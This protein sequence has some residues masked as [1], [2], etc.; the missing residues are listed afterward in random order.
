MRP[1]TRR[2]TAATG[3]SATVKLRFT[4]LPEARAISAET[5]AWPFSKPAV[6]EL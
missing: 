4:L 3:L 5:V 6:P 1:E 2:S